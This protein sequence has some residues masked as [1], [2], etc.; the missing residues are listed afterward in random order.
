MKNNETLQKSLMQHTDELYP[1]YRNK[2]MSYVNREGKVVIP[3]KFGWAEN[4]TGN[5]ARVT[6]NGKYGFI[7]RTGHYV[8]PPLYED[9]EK[10]SEGLAAVKING[11]WGFINEKGEMVIMPQFNYVKSF[12]NGRAFILKDGWLGIINKEGEIIREIMASR[13]FQDLNLN[14]DDPLY[15]KYGLYKLVTTY[16]CDYIDMNRYID[17][18]G[19]VFPGNDYYGA[20]EFSDGLAAVCHKKTEKWGYMDPTGKIV[21]PPQFERDGETFLTRNMIS[22]KGWL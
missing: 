8:I 21:I 15:K 16:Y 18:E 5:L 13:E 4:F 22:T 6:E 11:K 2:K 20:L 10:F 3:L 9:I 17:K 14:E 19:R 1:V 12:K 7:D